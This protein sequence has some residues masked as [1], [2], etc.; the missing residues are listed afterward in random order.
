MIR[1][2][3]EDLPFLTDLAPQEMAWILGGWGNVD[4]AN[5]TAHN[6]LGW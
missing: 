2:K 4:F 6:T 1:I 5:D 3:I